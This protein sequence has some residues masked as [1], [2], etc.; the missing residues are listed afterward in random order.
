MATKTRST[1]VESTVPVIDMIREDK[2]YKRA[3]KQFDR[4][5]ANVDP[6]ELSRELYS[7]QVS[8]GINALS[9]RKIITDKLRILIDARTVE[10]GTRSRC[11]TIRMM[12]L[13]AKL[14]IDEITTH[15]TKYILSKYHKQ[16]RTDGHTTITAMK[17]QVDV[18]LRT[19]LEVKRKLDHVDKLAVLVS[20]DVDSAHWGLRSIQD[21]MDSEQK[22]R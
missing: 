2:T 8:R 14:Q 10:I 3:K 17:A 4:A 15:L 13:E 9:S 20:E 16:L 21:A 12:A 5:T 11:T 1:K 22:D 7:L 6:E 18:Y 19:F